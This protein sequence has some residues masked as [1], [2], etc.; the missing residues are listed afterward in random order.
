M[1]SVVSNPPP[2]PHVVPPPEPPPV[3]EVP[4]NPLA[5]TFVPNEPHL[6]QVDVAKSSLETDT[7]RD[8]ED[9][10][11][12][13]SELS[14]TGDSTPRLSTV[15]SLW[16]DRKP[17]AFETAE[18]TQFKAHL[19]L[20]KSAG[21]V[22][23]EQPQDG[24]EWITLR[25]QRD[26]NSNSTPQH[27]SSQQT[28][29]RFRDLIEILNDLRLTGDYEPR[30]FTVGARL[31]R[32]NP[33]IY[34]DAG[35]TK[36][37]EYVRVA[38]EAGVVAI[39]GGRNGDASLD[40]RPAYCS[41]PVC[42]STPT[43]AASTPPIFV[44]STAPPFAPLVDF[45]KSE[46]STSSQPISS[47]R[48][49]VH[50]VSTLGYSGFVSL[51]TSAPG[52]TTFGQYIEAASDSGA[53]LLAGGT[54]TSGSTLVSPSDAGQACDVGL[55]LPDNPSH[56]AQPGVSTTPLLSS[57]SSK[58][59]AV[60]PPLVNA[61]SSSSSFLALV[62]VLR[63]LQAS[64]GESVFWFS[65]V[66]PILLETNPDAYGSVG[67]KSFAEYITL[68]MENGVVGVGWID[69]ADGWV[70]LV[71]LG[72]GRLAVSPSGI[73]TA[74][75]SPFASSTGGWV[76]PRFVDLVGILGGLWKKGYERPLLSHVGFELFKVGWR[77]PMLNACGASDFQ[78]YA[79]LAKDAG[80]VEIRGWRLGGKQTMELD[81]TIRAT[82]GFT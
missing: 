50:L 54:T 48:V 78:A 55:R 77:T 18:A 16:K 47:S 57:P 37:E 71:D 59:I 64:T 34:K 65:S 27:T 26:S 51:C 63:E 68:A 67:V 14:A 45:L 75:F 66:I 72:P 4:L 61:M 36:F 38:E 3:H 35:V 5:P 80:I 82:A 43:R 46:Q 31:R 81:P 11:V 8:F 69:Q 73:V 70:M 6:S 40:L 53:I 33:S 32:K 41:S 25:P 7:D 2:L 60:S 23:V 79:E 58:E 20:A 17:D 19:Q 28:I 42:S 21:I 52:V 30:F 1:R 39:R 9:L 74:L 56:S 12:V 13:L 44:A 62:L 49:F 22:A 15:F 10:I 29:S 24:D 76:D